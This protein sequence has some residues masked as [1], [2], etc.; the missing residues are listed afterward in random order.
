[1]KN[2]Y[3]CKSL[4]ATIPLLIVVA[5]CSADPA[6]QTETGEAVSSE[7]T[8]KSIAGI[9]QPTELDESM[10]ATIS[11][12]LCTRFAQHDDDIDHREQVI[13]TLKKDMPRSDLSG[14]G[15]T[16]ISETKNMPLVVAEITAE[17]LRKL[18]V[19][20]NIERIEPD[21]EMS[22]PES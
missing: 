13:I 4:L 3:L 1:M 16:V 15:I 11:K 21:G 2:N 7:P 5:G 14:R 22:I 6:Q 17:G 10:N 12:D 9:C 20:E 18:S 19:M 8:A